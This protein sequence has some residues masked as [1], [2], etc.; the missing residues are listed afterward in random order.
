MQTLKKSLLVFA[1]GLMLFGCKSS[2][3]LLPSISGK[4]GEI[5]V[6]MQKADWEG[7]LG[8]DTR[9]LLASEVPYLAQS[10]PMFNLI[11]VTPSNFSD[12]F[13]IH[14]NI[15]YFKVDPQLDTTGVFYHNDVWANPQCVMQVNAYTSEQAVEL[16]ENEGWRIPV[17]VEQAERNRVLENTLLY[18]EKT[19]SVKISELFEGTM[20][21]PTG[22]KIRKASKDF[23]WVADDK[24][25]VYQDVF[26]YRYPVDDDHPLTMDNIIRHRNSFLKANVPGMFENTY[27]KTSEY[28]PPQLEYVRFRGRDFAQVRGLWDVENDF[29]GGP[30]V[31]HSFYSP[32]GKDIIVLEAFVY[33]PRYDKRQYLRQVESLLYSWE[34]NKIEE[35]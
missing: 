26:I 3:P 4:A 12:L 22:Y 9:E 18:E 14:R 31:S 2:K 27:M 17:Y 25:Y 16:L 35:K 15:V 8:E 30:F 33:A 21:F 7:A 23:I 34:W 1:A 11:N 20:H 32:D 24:Q 10:E 6:V 19:I 29:M 28:F 13:K 5:I